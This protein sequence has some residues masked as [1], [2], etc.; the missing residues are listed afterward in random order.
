MIPP[1]IIPPALAAMAA[2]PQWIC[3]QL[4]QKPGKPKPDKVPTDPRTRFP[5]DAQNPLQ[6]MDAATAVATA[7]ATGLGIGF[8]FTE[9]DPFVFLDIDECATPQGPRPWADHAYRLI[10][11]LPGAAVETSC[12]GRGLHVFGRCARGLVHGCTNP[13]GMEL[14]TCRRFVALGT[15]AVNDAGTDCTAG[16]QA[17]AAQYF[18]PKAS[19]VG[20]EWVTGPVPGYGIADDDALVRKAIENSIPGQ[21]ELTGKA[22][23]QDLWEANEDVLSRYYRSGGPHRAYDDSSADAALASRLLF[24]TGGNCDQVQRIMWK[25]EALKRGKWDRD[26]YIPRTI[27]FVCSDHDGNYYR[28]PG[29]AAEAVRQRALIDEEMAKR[30]AIP[31]PPP[32]IDP[33]AFGAPPSALPP[34]PPAPPPPAPPPPEAVTPAANAPVKA[35]RIKDN[36]PY[37]EPQTTQELFEKYVYVES[38][39]RLVSPKGDLTSQSQFRTK[40]RNQV[41]ALNLKTDRTTTNA[42]KVYMEAE[43]LDTPQADRL[44]FRPGDPRQIILDSDDTLANIWRDPKPKRTQGDPTRFVNHVHTLLPNGDD[45]ERVLAY[46]A[47]CVQHQGTKFAWCPLIQGTYGNGKSLMGKVLTKVIGEK[48]VHELRS[49]SMR[50]QFNGWVQGHSL[51]C[52]NDVRFD[53]SKSTLEIVKPLITADRISVE[54]KGVDQVTEDVCCNF[55]MTSN[56]MD[57]IPLDPDERRW[58]VFCCAQQSRRERTRDGLTHA[59]FKSLWRWLTNEDGYAIVAEYLWT[60]AIPEE[61]NPAGSC[62]TAPDTTTHH[63]AVKAS[64]SDEA[65]FLEDAIET[66]GPG[67]K[68]GWISTVAATNA[69]R[70]NRVPT[71]PQKI[72]VEIAKLGYVRHPG[73]DSG[74]TPRNVSGEGKRTRLWVKEGHPSWHLR[75]GDVVTAYEKAQGY[76]V[77]GNVVPL[78]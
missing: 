53:G 32:P 10:S 14:Y 69:L 46:L 65:Q 23:F 2:Y 49:E 30:A 68:D 72:A 43:Y 66:A 54:R 33:T 7:N 67:F 27:M 62:L 78:R 34:P 29:A 44:C 4:I 28:T 11:Q 70:E 75:G 41:F 1:P 60:Y 12:S 18:P 22:S 58:A 20:V 6:W 45:A 17:I 57:A 55:L 74:K 61:M 19:A 77:V 71:T 76:A 31:P 25:C 15:G 13:L 35:S 37:I 47:A 50:S 24:W 40:F 21:H 26:D 63:L 73:L 48:Y 51:I 42:W 3:W 9:N 52:V 59:Y 8:V 16:F 36:Y 64:R 56:H 5:I 39:D 38:V